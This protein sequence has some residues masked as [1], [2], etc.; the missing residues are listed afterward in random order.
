MSSFDLPTIERSIQQPKT[1]DSVAAEIHP[2]SDNHASQ[3]T[4]PISHQRESPFSDA[5]QDHFQNPVEEQQRGDVHESDD[6]Y[7]E[8]RSASVIAFEDDVADRVKK[9]E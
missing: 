8:L 7:D 5:S 3:M 6:G 9:S 1:E 4:L 2:S